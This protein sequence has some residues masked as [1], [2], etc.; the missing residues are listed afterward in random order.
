M[1]RYESRT[2]LLEEGDAA[3]ALDWFNTHI[4]NTIL[5]NETSLLIMPFAFEALPETTNNFDQY[6]FVLVYDELTN[7][8][9]VYMHTERPQNLLVSH[10][11]YMNDRFYSIFVRRSLP[12]LMKEAWHSLEILF[13]AW[14]AGFASNQLFPFPLLDPISD[15]MLMKAICGVIRCTRQWEPWGAFM[16]DS[17]I[18]NKS[19]HLLVHNW[20]PFSRSINWPMPQQ[21]NYLIIQSPFLAHK[22]G[23]NGAPAEVDI[24]DGG[25]AL[26]KEHFMLAWWKEMTLPAPT[27][28]FYQQH[29]KLLIQTRLPPPKPTTWVK[30][31]RVADEAKQKE[32]PVGRIYK[33]RVD[34][35][36]FREL[37]RLAKL[38]PFLPPC[39]GLLLENRKKEHLGFK[40]RKV[41]GLFLSE[42]FHDCPE[43]GH[44]VWRDIMLSDT[45][46]RGITDFEKDARTR[47]KAYLVKDMIR[48]KMRSMN[49]S[50]IQGMGACPFTNPEDIEDIRLNKKTD[51]TAQ[52]QCGQ[53]AQ[54]SNHLSPSYATV[55][56]C[57]HHPISFFVQHV[58]CHYESMIALED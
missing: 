26:L 24:V 23:Y 4:A 10:R 37:D 3:H 27:H 50:S 38:E 51:Y 8:L 7:N 20:L 36:S 19:L 5:D 17:W 22:F 18:Q 45:K 48:D 21:H 39:I 6:D 52:S 15:L 30:R 55:L 25:M 56:S 46:Y 2:V 53:F 47:D 44:A 43:A 58:A 49:C 33:N 9:Y 28:P 35:I 14:R 16:F 1:S 57:D 32:E 42:I 31:V 13:E 12:L 34:G 40:E 41:I 29:A 54:K 11:R